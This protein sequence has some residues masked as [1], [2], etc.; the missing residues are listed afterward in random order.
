MEL[1]FC[2]LMCQH[3][4]FFTSSIE[5]LASQVFTYLEDKWLSIRADYHFT[6]ETL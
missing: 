2:G 1:K 4:Y 6:R 5:D 3:A